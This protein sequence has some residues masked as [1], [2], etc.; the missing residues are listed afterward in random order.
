MIKICNNKFICNNE[1]LDKVFSVSEDLFIQARDFVHTNQVEDGTCFSVVNTKG[2][3]LFRLQYR[4]NLVIR[5]QRNEFKGSKYEKRNDFLDYE[6]RFL[7][8]A[9]L[10]FLLLDQYSTFVFTEAEE[11]SLAIA[12][13]LEK[14]RP[15]KR[16]IFLDKRAGL[17]CKGKQI[18]CMP[19]R[20]G[21]SKYMELLKTWLQGSNPRIGL[22]SRTICLFL[23]KIVQRLEK[24]GGDVCIVA[25]EQAYF[26]PT[27]VIYNSVQI[28]Y[29]ILWC[30]TRKTLGNKN[31]NKTVFLLDYHCGA[32]GMVSIVNRTYMHIRWIL[33]EG[34]IPVV[35]LHLY[36]NQYLNTEEENMWEYFF[37]P[38]SD[39]S[40]KEAYES[41]NVISAYENGI[42]LSEAKINPYQGKWGARSFNS[43]EF[44]KIIRFNKD[45]KEYIEAKMPKELSG[46]VLGI[47]MRGTDY[48]A[49]RKGTVDIET[50]LQACL[51]YKNKLEYEY[52]FLATE[53]AEYFEIF[54]KSFG[55]RLLSVDQKRVWYDYKN[56]EYVPVKTLLD[57]RDG[58]EAGRNYLSVIYCLSLCDSMLYNVW[59]GAVNLAKLWN[60]G[61]YKVCEQILPGWKE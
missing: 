25:T 35:D 21:A 60:N 5:E 26:W 29:S 37:E 20:E 39:V 46:R 38:V 14:Y 49:W 28:M 7:D 58:R 33:A 45:T 43:E 42:V 2:K 41:E 24:K 16:C 57:P 3:P 22:L 36:P 11:Y 52:I 4:E 8:K 34:Y 51:H 56:K 10:D 40:T 44:S 15:E 12:G 6:K 54:K 47:V 13:L 48:R 23:W 30:K 50:F 32:E 31:R 55:D 18:R 1:M 27:D 53:D 59:C 61:K 9:S 17:F 19:L